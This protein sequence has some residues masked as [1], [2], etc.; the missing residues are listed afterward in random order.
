MNVNYL[1]LVILLLVFSSIQA[2]ETGELVDSRDGK[3]YKILTVKH[4]LEG[5]VFVTRTWMTQNLSYQVEGSFCYK[6]QRAYC[7]AYGRLYTF[8]GAIEACPEGWH[9]PTI[10]E[11]NLLI[12]NFGGKNEAGLALQRGGQSGINLD[13][14]GFGDPGSVFKNIGISGNYWDSE[15]KSQNT[16]GL[17]SVQ[18]DSKEVHHSLIGNWH[19]NSCRCI[20]DY[21]Y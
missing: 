6:K 8:R 18:K 10:G 16:A 15:K 12:Q 9:V 14:G 1:S 7:E 17:I 13:L 3:T 19:R 20:Q 11:W 21:E 5:G 4:E 2:Q